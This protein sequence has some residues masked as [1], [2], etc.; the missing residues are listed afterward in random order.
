MSKKTLLMFLAIIVIMLAVNKKF[1]PKGHEIENVD[2]VQV[3]GFDKCKEDCS[4]IEVTFISKLDRSTSE[5]AGN[6]IVKTISGSGHTA[7]EA[8]RNIRAKT[9]KRSFLGY[10][11]Y[12]LIG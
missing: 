3:I 11:D 4:K 8:Q 9:N 6:V 7:F 10:I 12:V 1:F 5:T 2:T